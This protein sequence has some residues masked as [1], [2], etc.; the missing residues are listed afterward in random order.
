M[1]DAKTS[2]YEAPKQRVKTADSGEPDIGW[3][4][5]AGSR[6]DELADPN[7]V[8]FSKDELPVPAVMIEQGV[9]IESYLA[10]FGNVEG[11][12]VDEGVLV[13]ASG[14]PVS[15][16]LDKRPAAKKA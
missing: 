6:P 15:E 4:N 13:D 2:A 5:Q 16:N 3:T 8:T 14:K 1:A 11:A 12:S 9:P 10:H 7:P